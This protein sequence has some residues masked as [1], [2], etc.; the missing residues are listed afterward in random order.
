MPADATNQLDS[1]RRPPIWYRRRALY[2]LWTAAAIVAILFLGWKLLWGLCLVFAAILLGVFFDSGA[3]IT[4]RLLRIRRHGLRLATFL[5]VLS[6]V[7]LGL[8]FF[9]GAMVAM[10]AQELSDQLPDSTV[11]AEQQIKRIPGGETLLS[12]LGGLDSIG[13]QIRGWASTAAASGLNFLVS[14]AFVLVTGLYLAAE[15]DIYRRGI[16]WLTPPRWR[17]DVDQTLDRLGQTLRYWLVGKIGAMLLVGTL[18]GVGLWILGVPLPLTNAI[19]TSLLTFIPNLGPIL[20]VVPP[21]LLAFGVSDGW[22]LS[23]PSLAVAVLGLYFLIQLAES[24]VI[25]PLFQKKAVELPPAILITAQL[26]AGTLIGIL[27]VAVAAPAVAVGMI[28]FRC[29]WVRG[30]VEKGDPLDD[31]PDDVAEDVAE[32]EEA[33]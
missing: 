23:G 10:Q 25:T 16:L 31:V 17:R 24:Y 8:V 18:S 20:S 3:R 13:T 33:E 6:L 19:I 1:P 14:L 29:L 27:G 11:A 21:V 30:D 26:L 22:L 9:A 7:M 12:T 4:G 5:G 2:P 28:L 32:D 15:P